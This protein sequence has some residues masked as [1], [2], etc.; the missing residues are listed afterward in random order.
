MIFQIHETKIRTLLKVD[1]A[2]ELLLF[3]EEPDTRRP[4]PS[5]SA[6]HAIATP[7]KWSKTFDFVTYGVNSSC[8]YKTFV[9]NKGGMAEQSNVV[10]VTIKVLKSDDGVGIGKRGKIR[11]TCTMLMQQDVETN[12]L[13]M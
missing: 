12:N 5:C 13:K 1:N 6:Y 9:V 11:L 8:S 3:S 10:D 7:P 2:R 4:I